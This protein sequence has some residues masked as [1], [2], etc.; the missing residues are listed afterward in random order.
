[1]QVRWRDI[2]D[3]INTTS[4]RYLL[5]VSGGVDSMFMLDFFNKNC[6]QPFR[7]AHFNH[8]LRPTSGDEVALVRSWCLRNNVSFLTA[9][10]D[11]DAMRAANSLEAEARNQRYA[12]FAS[13]KHADELVVT[14]HHANDQ[15][16]TVLMRL[17]RGVPH[18]QLRMAKRVADRYRPFLSV[19]REEI[20]RQAHNRRIEWIE[21]ES[22]AETVHE[23]NWMRHVI[24]PQLM[25]RRNVLKTIGLSMPEVS[26][27][28]DDNDASLDI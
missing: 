17:I 27:A 20:E 12:F 7:V 3:E 15:L 10:G 19:T 23:R 18:D 8:R 9:E 28:E 14:A 25:E 13:V 26:Y 5:C 21:D 16:E 24:I 2:I 22:N 11:P 4:D 6:R 1:M